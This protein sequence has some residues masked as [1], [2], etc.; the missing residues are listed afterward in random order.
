MRSH[1]HFLPVGPITLRIFA[2]LSSR[3]KNAFS[4][5]DHRAI[6]TSSLDQLSL[7]RVPGCHRQTNRKKHPDETFLVC[8]Y[9]RPK[10]RTGAPRGRMD[11]ENIAALETLFSSG[12]NGRRIVL[13]LKDLTLVDRDSGS[14]LLRSKAGSTSSRISRYTFREWMEREKN[15]CLRG[16]LACAALGKLAPKIWR[17]RV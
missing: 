14:F 9:N 2:R 7:F 10:R 12:A 5:K 8:E 1:T 6:T 13:R 16:T 17:V 11:A 15:E 4:P 3:S